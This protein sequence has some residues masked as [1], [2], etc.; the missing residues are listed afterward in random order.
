MAVMKTETDGDGISRRLKFGAIGKFV[1][2][3]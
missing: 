3:R 2:I 1:R